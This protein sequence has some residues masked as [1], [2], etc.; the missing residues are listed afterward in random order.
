[1]SLDISSREPP[2]N[3]RYRKK[4]QFQHC[5]TKKNQPKI[6]QKEKN[7]E[8]KWGNEEKNQKLGKEAYGKKKYGR[9]RHKNGYW[10]LWHTFQKKAKQNLK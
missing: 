1:M 3:S 2:A 4:H 6:F 7:K 10:G 9:E 8:K 5:D